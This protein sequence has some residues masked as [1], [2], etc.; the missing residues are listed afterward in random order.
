MDSEIIVALI[1]GGFTVGNVA[2]TTIANA[3][4]ARRQ[5]KEAAELKQDNKI[6]LLEDGIQSLLRAEIIRSHEE[7]GDKGYCPV[8][9]KES[10]TKAYKAYHALG[11]NDVAT[12][13]Y[14]QCMYLPDKRRKGDNDEN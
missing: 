3:L 10:L 8:Y 12:E 11:G 4:A 13:L 5:R 2:F 7:Y 1:G 9:A 14:K 6:A